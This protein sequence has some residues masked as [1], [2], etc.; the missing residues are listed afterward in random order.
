[1]KKII[2]RLS[3]EIGNQMFMYASAYSIS[4][5]MNR[6][7]FLDNE[8]AYLSKKN[9]SKYGLYNFKVSS[10]IAEDK[11]KFKNNYG[12]IK[13]KFFL[14]TE[15]LRPSKKFFI[16]KKDKNKITFFDE[17][18]INNKFDDVI[19]L[20]GHFES[21]KYF[22]NHQKD[23]MNEF[24]FKDELKFKNIPFFNQINTENSVG[25]CIR[26]NR[27][28]EGRGKNTSKNAEKSRKFTLEQI[29][30][31]NKSVSLIKTKLN[32]PIFYLWSNDLFSIPEDLL[33]FKFKKIDLTSQKIKFDQRIYSLFLLS[34]CKHFIVTTSTFNWW[35][36]WLSNYKN[37]II[38]RPD[39]IFFS[40]FR[41][42]N[43]DFWPNDWIKLGF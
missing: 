26:Q 25:I 33:E 29:R 12:Y 7:L 17:K 14:K 43:R 23:I 16:E 21:P 40:N 37:K 27:F 30:Y 22:I 8:T 31:I 36:A 41:V 18:F 19:Y 10:P 6:N 35:G 38:I 15:F 5:K 2:L 32:N 34:Q 20:E 9:V 39:D 24:K 28:S 3:N 42:N 1:M 13:R 4:K 11:L